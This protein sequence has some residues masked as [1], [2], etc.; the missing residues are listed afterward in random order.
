[1]DIN[2]ALSLS[3]WKNEVRWRSNSDHERHSSSLQISCSYGMA[4]MRTQQLGK[5]GLEAP[6][7]ASGFSVLSVT[8]GQ[9]PDDE[10]RFEVLHRVY[11]LGETFLGFCRCVRRQRSSACYVVQAC[12]RK[13]K[14]AI[15]KAIDAAEVSRGGSARN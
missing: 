6:L 1:M 3:C 8:Y 10:D 12:W 7:T 15:Q 5:A 11:E 14:R 9:V 4:P 2:R 13:E